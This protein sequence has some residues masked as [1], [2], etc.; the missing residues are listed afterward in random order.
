MANNN[1]RYPLIFLILIIYKCIIHIS[2]CHN[3]HTFFLCNSDMICTCIIRQDKLSSPNHFYKLW[4]I[5]FLHHIAYRYFRNFIQKCID[6]ARVTFCSAYNQCPACF[7]INSSCNFSKTF[8]WP[9]FYRQTG[10]RK[11]NEIFFRKLLLYLY[12]FQNSR[13]CHSFFCPKHFPYSR[14]ELYLVN[15]FIRYFKNPVINLFPHPFRTLC[16]LI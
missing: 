14:I 10:R 7:F 16:F 4:Y 11:H 6:R 9:L 1:R 12:F 2:S 5:C 13:M 15:I 8:N 3:T